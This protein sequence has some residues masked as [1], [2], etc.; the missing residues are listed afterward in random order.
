MKMVKK[1]IVG[2]MI[3]CSWVVAQAGVITQTFDSSWQTGV[4][5]Y[6]NDIAA[7]EWEYQTY[8]P[9]DGS[10][11]NLT[12]VV[13]SSKFTGVREDVNDELRV[14][15]AFFTGWEPVNYQ[16][17]KTVIIDGGD[18][19]FST[20]WS[21]SY[22]TPEEIAVITNYSYFT[23]IYDRGP[24]TGGAWYYFESRTENGIHSIEATTTLSYYYDAIAVN[25]P[26]TLPLLGIALASLIFIRLKK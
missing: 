22:N 12:S 20:N 7:M 8:T 3:S 6:Y 19:Q 1:I 10:M 5:D 26:T 4:W 23:G 18:N 16:Y 25:S 13:I 17:S 21:Q 2:I 24:G 14:R 9:W 15:S 11:G